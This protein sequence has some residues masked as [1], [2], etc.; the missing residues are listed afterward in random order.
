M[1]TLLG[2]S[3]DVTKI[4]KTKLQ[5]GRYLNLTVSVSD[6][7][8]TY[9]QNVSAYHEQSKEEREAKETK[10][11][12]GNGKVFWTDGNISVA[13]KNTDLQSETGKEDL[14]F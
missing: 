6:D 11:Y 7:S 4:D 10:T 2:I 12:L 5:K 8:N 13:E 9:G 3:I 14:P 1:S